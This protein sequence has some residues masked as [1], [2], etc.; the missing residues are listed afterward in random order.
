MKIH[1]LSL[2]LTSPRNGSACLA[3]SKNGHTLLYLKTSSSTFFFVMTSCDQS[4]Y[5]LWLLSTDQYCSYP[6]LIYC[7]P[8][9]PVKLNLVSKAVA[10]MLLHIW[11]QLCTWEL[12][13]KWYL[14][15]T[16][17]RHQVSR[18]PADAI[19]LW[20]RMTKLVL[21]MMLNW[22]SFLFSSSRFRHAIDRNIQESCTYLGFQFAPFNNLPCLICS[23]SAVVTIAVISLLNQFRIQR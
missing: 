11:L 16:D 12:P 17:C 20:R 14:A 13:F 18:E 10:L 1:P 3:A 19:L 15:M 6:H 22:Q 5:V 2:E 23:T 21:D 8:P 7:Q 9:R 4:E